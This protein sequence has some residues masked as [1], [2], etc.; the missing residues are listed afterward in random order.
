MANY[1]NTLPL[2]L[3]FEELGKCDFMDQSE[4]ADGGKKTDW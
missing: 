1:F 4:F 3:K 2:R